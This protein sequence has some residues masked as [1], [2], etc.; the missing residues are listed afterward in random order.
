MSFTHGILSAAAEPHPGLLAGAAITSVVFTF[1]YPIL[2]KGLLPSGVLASWFLGTAVLS[3][4]GAGGFTLVC[5]YFVAGT[6]V[7]K[8]KLAQKQTEG[9][10]EAR[11]GQRGPGSVLGS[12]IAGLACALLALQTGNYALLQTGFVASF[13]SKLSDTVSSEVGKAYGKTTYL[14][15]SLKL[16]ARGTEG[17]VSLEGSLAGV[18]A[19][20]AFGGIAYAVGQVD[21]QGVAAVTIASVVANVAESYVGATL[22]GK[23]E[24]I[25]NDVVNMAQITLA[26]ALAIAIQASY[27][28]T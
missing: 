5:F 1:G 4:F 14:I 21:A 22:Q 20:A 3:A 16:V 27:M 13:C 2:R 25:T 6:A 24:W 23:V 11:S 19:A 18:A 9:I 26:A 12:G 15:T 28:S 7:T 8:L 17:A 10:A